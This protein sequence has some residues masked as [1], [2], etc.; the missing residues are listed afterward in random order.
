MKVQDINQ[1]ITGT[2][3]VYLKDRK[4]N[5]EEVCI[6]TSTGNRFIPL[7]NKTGENTLP[8]IGQQI[9]VHCDVLGRDYYGNPL[10]DIKDFQ[11]LNVH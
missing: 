9:T 1:I 3:M 11:P 7:L 8:L 5:V 10:I 2:V 4:G 6:Q